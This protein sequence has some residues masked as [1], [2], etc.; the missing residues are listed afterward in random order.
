MHKSNLEPTLFCVSTFCEM[1]NLSDLAGYLSRVHTKP[2]LYIAFVN[3][4]E[5][6]VELSQE[7]EKYPRLL[8]LFFP[9]LDKR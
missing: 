9:G 4:Q 5:F 1:L 2:L 8:K 7:S 3:I 6:I